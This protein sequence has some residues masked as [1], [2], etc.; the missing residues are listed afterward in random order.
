M[1]RLASILFALLTA[2]V[3]LLAASQPAHASGAPIDL[4]DVIKGL[5][6]RI[7]VE[8]PPEPEMTPDQRREW[9]DQERAYRAQQAASKAQAASEANR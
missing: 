8:K 3:L 6:Q 1:I 5:F 7:F 9:L 4:F 2:C